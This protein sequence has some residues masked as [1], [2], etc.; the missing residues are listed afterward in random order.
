MIKKVWVYDLET[1]PN[2]FCAVFK[3]KDDVRVFEISE[4]RNDWEVLNHFLKTEVE[5]LKGYNNISFDNQIIEYIWNSEKTAEQ[6]S[7]FSQKVIDSKYPIYN[8]SHLFNLDIYKILHLD[9]KNR[10]VG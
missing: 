3:C 1:L 2:F 5:A 10:M 6:I 7:A 9:N 4:W 8:T